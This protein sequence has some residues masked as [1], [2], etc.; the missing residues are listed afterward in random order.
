MY[1]YEIT[2]YGV[3]SHKILHTMYVHTYNRRWSYIAPLAYKFRAD[4]QPKCND[5]CV[6]SILD[7]ILCKLALLPIP[8]LLSQFFIL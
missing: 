6:D 8:Q 7:S 2:W 5:L 4:P 3:E 1:S